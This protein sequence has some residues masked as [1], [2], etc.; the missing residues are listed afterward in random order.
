MTIEDFKYYTR[1][2]VDRHYYINPSLVTLSSFYI[3]EVEKPKAITA[4]TFVWLRS[5]AEQEMKIYK[6]TNITQP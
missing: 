2:M 3:G 5:I 4:Q 6:S 1:K